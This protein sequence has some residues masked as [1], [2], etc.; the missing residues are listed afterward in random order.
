MRKKVMDL[1]KKRVEMGKYSII[2]V[3]K[4]AYYEKEK[5]SC[6]HFSGRFGFKW[7]WSDWVVFWRY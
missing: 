2:G 7:S 6:L 4:E 1:R 5:D 3:N